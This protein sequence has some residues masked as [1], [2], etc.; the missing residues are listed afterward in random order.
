V[1]DKSLTVTDDVV[2]SLEYTLWLDEGGEVVD[3]SENEEP[4]EF[5]QGHGEIVPGLEQALYGMSVGDEKRVVV[6]PEDGYGELDPDAFQLLPRDAFP[7]DVELEPGMS[8]ELQDDSGDVML[9]FVAEIR[10]DSI[11][12][13]FNH[14]LAGEILHFKVKVV[15]LRPATPEELEHD[16]VHFGT[17]GHD[18]VHFGTDGH[19]PVH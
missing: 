3:S 10:K 2:V 17:D 14:P 4:L 5:I 15:G 11:L 13:D 18:H 6:Q 8:L 12:L 9:A 7:R 16:H 19:D 1:R